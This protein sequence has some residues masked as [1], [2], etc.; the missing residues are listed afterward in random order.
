MKCITHS[1]C[2]LLILSV[3]LPA[4]AEEGGVEIPAKE[5]FH[6]FLLAGQS[7]MAGRGKVAA[8]DKVAHPRVLVLAKDGKWRPAVDP[9]HWDKGSA[10]VGLGR[11]FAIALAE[12]NDKVTIGLIPAAC[13]GSPISTWTSG[14]YHGQTKSHPYDDAIARARRARQDGTLKGILWHQGESD[15]NA[16]AAPQIPGPPHRTDRPFPQRFGGPRTPLRHRPIGPIQS[17][18]LERRQAPSRRRPPGDRRQRPTHR[19]RPVQRPNQQPRQHPLRCRVAKK[20]RPAV[21]GCL[22]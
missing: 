13:G 3:T 12:N 17:Q 15:S 20:I 22:L 14:G 2:F 16:A 21:C 9:L 19:L 10:G 7:N 8:E 4:S 6:L 11:A 1:F 5:N 18:P